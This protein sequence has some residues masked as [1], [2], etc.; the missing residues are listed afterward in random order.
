MLENLNKKKK[1]LYPNIASALDFLNYLK[2]PWQTIDEKGSTFTIQKQFKE[3]NKIK[4]EARSETNSTEGIA[5]AA[6]GKSDSIN[7]RSNGTVVLQ[8]HQVGCGLD[9]VMG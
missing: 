8:R 5:T 2:N 1:I 7:F 9:G 4:E 3:L 6:L